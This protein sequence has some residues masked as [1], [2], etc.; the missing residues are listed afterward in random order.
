MSTFQDVCSNQVTSYP[1]KYEYAIVGLAKY[2][3]AA[4]GPAG[5]VSTGPLFEVKV[6]NI[7]QQ[8]CT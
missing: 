5:Q 2:M 7:K 6:M 3:A 1:G 8:P 4:T